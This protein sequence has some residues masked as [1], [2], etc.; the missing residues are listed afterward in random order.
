MTEQ[1]MLIR[2]VVMYKT[3]ER[4]VQSVYSYVAIA[5]GSLFVLGVFLGRMTR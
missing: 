4:E 2:L 1:K 3:L 5:A